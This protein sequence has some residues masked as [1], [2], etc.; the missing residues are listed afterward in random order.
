MILYLL[1]AVFTNFTSIGIAGTALAYSVSAFFIMMIYLLT[2]RKKTGIDIITDN[3]GYIV[4]AMMAVIPSGL[5]TLVLKLLV[6]PDVASKLS[7]VLAV[8]VPVAGGVT[9]Y[10]LIRLKLKP[11]RY[12]YINNLVLW[13]LKHGER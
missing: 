11:R 13:R 7:Q 4:K 12:T 2:F 8:C 10:W 1:N 5:I 6:R 3:F 9:I